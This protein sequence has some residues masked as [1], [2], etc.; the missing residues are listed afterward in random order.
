[1]RTCATCGQRFSGEAAFCP[2][3]GTKLEVEVGAAAGPRP[4]DEVGPG[5]VIGGVYRVDRVLGEGGMGTVFA[6]THTRLN[7][8]FALKMLKK[9][10]ARDPET[11]ARFLQEAQ[12]AGQIQHPN[13]VEITDFAALPDGSA[14]MVMEYLDGQ[15]L[16]RMIKLGGALPALRAVTL[17]RD[18]AK[19][20]QAAHDASVVHRDLKPDNVF[21]LE[22]GGRETAKILDFGVAK[23]AGSAKLT[24]TGM[25]FGTP[26]YMSPEQA[27]GGVV[28]GRTDIY[29]LGVIMYEMFTGRVPF[30]ADT[31]MGV[32]T[33]HMF[34]APV[35]PS[36]L[37]GPA[38]ELGALED[39]TL[40]ALAKRPEDRY[41]SMNELIAD[42]DRIVQVGPDGRA[43][44]A[45]EV[46]GIRRPV[47][48]PGQPGRISVAGLA[49]EL[50]P[51][52]R[53]EIDAAFRTEREARVQRFGMIVL[54]AILGLGLVVAVTALVLRRGDGRAATK[55]GDLTEKGEKASEKAGEK[56]KPTSPSASAS[57]S[58]TPSVSVP[59]SASAAPPGSAVP[60]ASADPP[61]VAPPPATTTPPKWTPPPP[62]TTKKSGG[63]DID[64]P[65]AKKN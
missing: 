13:V 50:E 23:V 53:A 29:A 33:K 18:V 6:V 28:D 40:K 36:Q 34:E 45:A 15:P 38:R 46:A 8:R 31:Y 21:V 30:E 22:I 64:D 49:D 12:A 44:I 3:D 39:L 43:I 60:P 41:S 62:A 19:A 37:P 59:P 61:P 7:K 1:M 5:A 55:G 52:H 32:L 14:Y 54:S 27:S 57:T 35:P 4:G 65:W 11:R 10:L 63:E 26:H 47:F 58:A 20:L 25:V 17:V 16:A 2:F 24:R 9:D 48:K 51:P 56:A 42:L